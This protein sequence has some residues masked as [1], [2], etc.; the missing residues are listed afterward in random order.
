MAMAIPV[1]AMII[2]AT[3]AAYPIPG[4]AII[5]IQAI[6]AADGLAAGNELFAR[7]ERLLV[8]TY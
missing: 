1:A 2:G 3:M 6:P 7:M 8:D 4:V 5:A